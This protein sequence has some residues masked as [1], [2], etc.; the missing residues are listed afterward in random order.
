MKSKQTKIEVGDTFKIQGFKDSYVEILTI[1]EN[2]VEYLYGLHTKDTHV[3]KCTTR[4]FIDSITSTFL[5]P[6]GKVAE[7]IVIECGDED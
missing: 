6:T 2:C 3:Y 7:V 5:L 1:N 4:G